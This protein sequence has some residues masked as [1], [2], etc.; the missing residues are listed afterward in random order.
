[1]GVVIG[2]VLLIVGLLASV[3][4]IW[5]VVW[6]FFKRRIL[7]RPDP[8]PATTKHIDAL[9]QQIKDLE[10]K[11]TVGPEYLDGLPTA[12]NQKLRAAYQEARVLQ[13]EGYQA[14]SADRHREA[15][16]RFAR[17]LALAEN[18]AQRAALYALRGNSYL[19]ISEYHHAEAEYEETLRLADRISPAE[20][21]ARARVPALGNLG[22]VSFEQGDLD[23]AEEQHKQA[24][25]VAKKIGYHVAEAAALGNLGLVYRHRGDMNKAEEHLQKA[26]DMQRQIGDRLGQANQLG[27]LGNVYHQRGGPGDLDRAE[28]HFNQ[29]LKMHR[30]IG[31]RS[32]LAAQLGNLGIVY[33]DRGEMGRAERYFQQALLIDR[34]IG[35]RRGEADDL[36]NLGLLYAQRGKLEKA[37]EYLQQA[38]AIYQ[39]IGTG[40]ERPETVRRALE[41]IEEIERK[42]REGG[43]EV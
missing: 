43:E 5:Q 26:L 1:M 22:V 29:A 28:Q 11:V 38:Q 35:S 33:A 4:A 16:D 19:S 42:Q 18:D 36:N 20:D 10:S 9:A 27:N 37:K 34:E 15:I 30:E 6:P 24:L 14:Q 3:I 21:A 7:K 12:V 31:N 17:A 41:R 23:K 8:Q 13:L 2:S 40:G 39:Q 25:F 32:G